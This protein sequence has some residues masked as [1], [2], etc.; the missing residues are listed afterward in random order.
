MEYAAFVQENLVWIV[1]GAVT[2]LFALR[3]VNSSRIKRRDTELDRA[4]DFVESLQAGAR[5]PDDI[6][7]EFVCW[8]TRTLVK[9][10][11]VE[12][13]EFEHK[14]FNMGFRTKDDVVQEI[15]Y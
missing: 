5:I 12:D 11:E 4:Y 14:D 8:T 15:W 9:R 3:Y 2:I 1:T 13:C 6:P 7:D 10:K